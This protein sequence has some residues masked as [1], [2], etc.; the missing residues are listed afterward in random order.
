MELFRLSSWV[1]S[2]ANSN[3]GKSCPAATRLQ[4][5]WHSILYQFTSLGTQKIPVA[6]QKAFSVTRGT[7][8]GTDAN[9][10]FWMHNLAKLTAYW[11]QEGCSVIDGPKKMSEQ[12][13]TQSFGTHIPETGKPYGINLGTW[14]RTQR[15]TKMCTKRLKN[16]PEAKVGDKRLSHEQIVNLE[17][18]GFEWNMPY[19]HKENLR[20]GIIGGMGP[21]A[22]VAFY[23]NG[24]NFVFIFHVY[25]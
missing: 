23:Q 19:T 1:T 20:V 22:T 10:K 6:Y 9:S 15:R 12:H 18:I 3:L 2:I 5:I 11:R 14:C 8:F 13:Q 4:C 21:D 16:D 7:T 17:S 25:S 24:E